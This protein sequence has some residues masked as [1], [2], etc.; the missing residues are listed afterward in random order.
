[1]STTGVARSEENAHLDQAIQAITQRRDMALQCCM[2]PDRVVLLSILALA[3]LLMATTGDIHK[4]RLAFSN[5]DM[6][7]RP[8]I[9]SSARQ[10]ARDGMKDQAKKHFN[11]LLSL[12]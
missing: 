3:I 7:H 10:S 1:M 5:L 8:S 11:Y 4:H 2:V 9:Q 12:N 6:G